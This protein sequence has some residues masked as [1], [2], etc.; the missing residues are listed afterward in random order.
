[1]QVCEHYQIKLLA[2]KIDEKYVLKNDKTNKYA[3]VQYG[4]IWNT[5]L[6]NVHK[7]AMEHQ[8]MSFK[9]QVLRTSK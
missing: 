1:M 3:S 8:F 6:H 7:I 4:I 5:V 9:S 2:W